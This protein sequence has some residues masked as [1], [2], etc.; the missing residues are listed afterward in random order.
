MCFVEIGSQEKEDLILEHRVE[1][2]YKILTVV[3]ACEIP[4]NYFIGDGK[5]EAGRTFGALDFAGDPVFSH[6]NC[7][8]T[9][10]RIAEADANAS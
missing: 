10:R 2:N 6:E 4:A 7:S 9:K 8:W 3:L 5:E 1:T